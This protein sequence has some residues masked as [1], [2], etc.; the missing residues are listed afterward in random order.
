MSRAADRPLAARLAWIA[1]MNVADSFFTLVHLQGGGREL[2]PFADLLLGTGRRGFVVAKCALISLALVVLCVHKN[3]ALA[4]V[5][6]WAAAGCYTL[7]VLY[8]LTL[9]TL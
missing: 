1:L 3:F 8:H 4:R 7:L 5:G 2:N 6:L 9:F